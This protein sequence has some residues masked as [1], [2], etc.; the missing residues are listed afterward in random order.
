MKT[1]STP[2]KK[3]GRTRRVWKKR[4]GF[5]LIELLIVVAIIGILAGIAIPSFV[6]ARNKT[7]ISRVF[8]DFR[9]IGEA[10]ETYAVDNIGYPSENDGLDELTPNYMP[11][12]P[13]DPF[14]GAGYRYYTDA[15]A[16]ATGSAWLI[17]SNGPDGSEDVTDGA[18]GFSWA[19]DAPRISG[20]VG[21]PD[22]P[23]AGYGLAAGDGGWY[24]P[25]GDTRDGDLGRGGP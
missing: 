9:I 3:G 21:G 19:D 23:T 20:Q 4:E 10:L 24:N 14:A 18:A 25:D 5:T 16:A 7:K 17:V 2:D 11:S 1:E 13:N 15:A 8:A 22:A 6:R 12:M